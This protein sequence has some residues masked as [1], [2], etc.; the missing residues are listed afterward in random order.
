MRGEQLALCEGT[1]GETW[2]V[3]PGMRIIA[4]CDHIEDATRVWAGLVE[5]EAMAAY[6]VVNVVARNKGNLGII[7]E[8]LAG[9]KSVL[10][11]R[12]IQD[13]LD[14]LA[15]YEKEHTNGPHA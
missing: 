9:Q 12:I 13:I 15:A 1:G 14:A 2:I 11:P 10:G 8:M 5:L 6:K 3:G 7:K 4:R